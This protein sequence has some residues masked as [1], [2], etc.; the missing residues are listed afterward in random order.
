MTRPDWRRR[1]RSWTPR[2]WALVEALAD[3]AASDLPPDPAA[4]Q[5]HNVA[6]LLCAA[7]AATGTLRWPQGWVDA[8]VARLVA[9]GCPAPSPATMSWY[10]TRLSSEPLGF[11]DVPGVDPDLLQDIADG[12]CA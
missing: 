2:N 6:R 10:R 5:R 8:F 11:R 4:S 12:V 9:A 3:E 7:A 1:S